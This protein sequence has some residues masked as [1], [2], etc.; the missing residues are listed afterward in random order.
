MKR[1][2]ALLLLV[3][4]CGEPTF[5]TSVDTWSGAGPHACRDRCSLSW[6]M[7]QLSEEERA[8][9]EAVRSA[10]RV[11]EYI[12]VVDGT[13]FSFMSYYKEGAA[14]G[15]RTTTVAVLDHEEASWGWQMDGWAFVQLEACGNWAIIRNAWAIPP[16]TTEYLPS[17]PQPLEGLS[18]FLVDGPTTGGGGWEPPCCDVVPPPAAIPAP[19]AGLLLLSALGGLIFW[20]KKHA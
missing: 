13:A 20:R 2:L 10:S 16:A 8:E 12:P 3:A 1:S 11:V 4:S 7:S 6:A 9:F 18:G 17:Q 5:A 19:N 15:Y 14:R